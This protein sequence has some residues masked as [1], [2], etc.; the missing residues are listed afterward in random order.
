MG[1][2]NDFT[3]VLKSISETLFKFIDK[4]SNYG[5]EIT[6]KEEFEN[7][8]L[9]LWCKYNSINFGLKIEPAGE[10]KVNILIHH[11]GKD[12]KLENINESDV[13]KKA[14]EVLRKE[15]QINF[16]NSVNSSKR[17]Q[18][19]LQ[20]ITSSDEISINLT[21]INANYDAGLAVSDLN[22]LLD[23]DE[24]VDSITDEPCCYEI[25][26]NG[27]EF[28]ISTIDDI[29][30]TD[31]CTAIVGTAMK[32]WCNM[33]VIHWA[34][35]GK[36]FGDLHSTCDNFRWRLMQEIEFFG[37][38]SVELGGKVANPGLYTSTDDI[39][40]ITNDDGAGFTADFGF[41]LISRMIEQ[42]L[43][44]LETYYVNFSHDVQN[45]L[46]REIREWNKD[47][48]YFIKQ[49]LK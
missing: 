35:I 38:L 24:F 2:I 3:K 23:N 18:V 12:T 46:D 40:P 10:G 48:N 41:E 45:W 17:L 6:K 15:V 9:K 47:V 43:S 32:I 25:T 11:N 34:A 28:D 31:L 42:Y 26:D 33:S 37:E 44:V 21:A 7:G 39:L 49:R 4:F 27:D 30:V 8:G 22:T 36:D 1:V 20:R 16:D 29:L 14:M 19:K 13:E 5:I